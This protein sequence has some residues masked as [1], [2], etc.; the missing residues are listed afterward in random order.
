MAQDRLYG[1][2][3]LKMYIFFFLLPVYGKSG[4]LSHILVLVGQKSPSY[5]FAKVSW[6]APNG[7]DPVSTFCH[8]FP[9]PRSLEWR[10]E[11]YPSFS[12]KKSSWGDRVAEKVSELALPRMM[13][14][15]STLAKRAMIE[16]AFFMLQ[17]FCL[18]EGGRAQLRLW[19]LQTRIKEAR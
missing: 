4:A 5:F 1:R 19:L 2:S 17:D 8:C 14:C 3:D 9:S 16:N 7:L 11:F 13:C 12:T 18:E 6:A 10:K 15:W